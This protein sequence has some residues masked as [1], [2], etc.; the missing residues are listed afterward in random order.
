[1]TDVE[2]GLLSRIEAIRRFNRFHTRLV[3]ALNEDLLASDLPL[4][5]VRLLYDL[6][7]SDDLSAADLSAAL[8]LNPGYL[9]RLLAQLET[10]GLIARSPDPAH[11]KRL[12]IE[13]T[14]KGRD[15][16][17]GLEDR[18]RAEIAGL[19]GGLTEAD[20]HDLVA[21]MGRIEALL[22][23]TAPPEIILR[24]PE[25]GDLGTVVA[26]QGELY[27]RE[28]G[29]DRT[30]E[31]LVAGIVADFIRDFD[32]ELEM[33]RIAA[34]EGEVVGSVFIIKAEPG[35]AKLRLLYVDARVRGQGLGKRLVHEAIGFARAKGY[36]ELVLWTNAG[37]DA[38]RGIYQAAGFQLVSEE[39][40]HSF[41][42][43]LVG[44]YWSL[45]L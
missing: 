25:P 44:Q 37:L 17:A 13:L 30:F 5:Q 19:I 3:G 21:C 11:A 24:D 31:G 39:P 45:K 8:S 27:A 23:G 9:S 16:V 41:G 35:I 28:Y 43:D 14:D 18:S 38:A 6:A 33:A 15:L 34:R 2:P 42:H 29:F 12:R 4:V 7:H 26:R 1:M 36:R 20:Q 32:P 22:G 10:L 40:H